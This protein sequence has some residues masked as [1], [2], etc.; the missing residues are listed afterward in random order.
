MHFD[1][2]SHK[3]ATINTDMFAAAEKKSLMADLC[4]CQQV[5]QDIIKG[6]MTRQVKLYTSLHS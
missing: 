5:V 6:P 3:I 4:F 2:N 1:N